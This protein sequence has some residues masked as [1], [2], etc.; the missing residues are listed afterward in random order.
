MK[1]GSS[2]DLILLNKFQKVSDWMQDNFGYNNFAIARFLRIAMIISFVIREVLSFL[3]GIDSSEIIVMACSIM[4]IIKMD[5]ILRR[6]QQSL[7]NNP[8]FKNP[9]VSEYAVTRILIQFVGV[10]AFGFLIKHLYY[11]VNPSI[12]YADQLDQCKDFFWD[13][14]GTLMFLVAYF[15]SCTPKPYKTSKA[16]KLLEQTSERL[17]QSAVMPL[18]NFLN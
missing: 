8:A 12:N 10:A 7:Q 3:K 9:I 4:V 2:V 5:F 17:A 13:L 14:F 11:I 18:P 6:A 15:S 16:K 1:S